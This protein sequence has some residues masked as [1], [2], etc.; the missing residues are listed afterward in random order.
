MEDDRFIEAYRPLVLK[1]AGQLQRSLSLSVDLDELVAFGFRGLLEARD[2]FDSTRGVQFNTFAYYRVRGAIVDGI[3]DMAYLPRR[4]HARLRAAEAQDEIVETLGESLHAPTAPSAR[5][6]EE[7]AREI[8]QTLGKLAASYVLSSLG[9]GEDD[10]PVQPEELVVHKA[11]AEELRTAVE[12]LPER[13]KALVT[14]FYFEGRRFD[15][16]ADELGISKSWA[17]RL[18]TKAL[19]RLRHALVEP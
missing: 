15:E 18:H 2:R 11:R 16:I 12:D 4:A 14:G 10:G 6:G 3:R 17:S 8:D 1:L 5:S 13:E 7:A 9:H 19:E